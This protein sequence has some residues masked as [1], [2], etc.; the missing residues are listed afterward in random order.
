MLVCGNAWHCDYLRYVTDFPV[1][2]GDVLAIVTAEGETQIFVES[3]AEADR[4]AIACPQ[5]EVVWAE[6][7]IGHVATRLEGMANRRIAAA[8]AAL[9]PYGISQ[10]KPFETM[11]DGTPLLDHLLLVK[12]PV[13]IE[14]VRRAAALA[15]RGYGVFLEAARVGRAEY[16]VV[17]DIEAFYRTQGCAENFMIMG[18]GGPELRGM[19]P[20]GERRLREGDLVTTELTPAIEGY[21][22]Q[23]CRTLVLG[24]PSA[25]Q[26][27]TFEVFVEAAAAGQAVL[28]AGITADAV[29]KAENDVFRKYGLGEY[30]TS[31][32]TR[33]R[34]TA[35]DCSSTTRPI[36][37]KTSRPCSRR[38]RRSLFI[39]TPTTR[40]SV[41]WCW[42]T[43][44]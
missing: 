20:P 35:S 43:C 24:E 33:V 22:A 34:G 18:S 30:T 5:A 25:A 27:K 1:I 3:P 17:A 10:S 42:A 4:A 28:R 26:I 16:E 12:S 6:G 11:T 44:L 2:E 37:S 32:Y 31:E 40:R 36:F 15:E 9:M 23:I 7:L 21:Y 13:E 8:P 14:T 41:T 39:P 38:A 29:A 19:H